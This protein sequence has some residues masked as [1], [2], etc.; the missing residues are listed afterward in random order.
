MLV[1]PQTLVEWLRLAGAQL[2][3]VLPVVRLELG[4]PRV[5]W[6]RFP[7][8]DDGGIRG[9]DVGQLRDCRYS[10]DG[11]DGLHVQI[12]RGYVEAHL[13]AQDP[14]RDAAAHAA[15]D[16]RLGPGLLAGTLLGGLLGGVIGALA[17][18]ASGAIAGVTRPRR[19]RQLLTLEQ[20]HQVAVRRSQLGMRARA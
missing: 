7:P 2:A 8:C 18:A 13:D 3:G 14:R 15:A 11:P 5:G 1:T 10:T 20:L 6:A 19:P 4:D 17:G 12:F 16:T 9:I